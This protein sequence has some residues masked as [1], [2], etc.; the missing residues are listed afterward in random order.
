MKEK[1]LLL[2]PGEK[3]ARREGDSGDKLIFSLHFSTKEIPK[4]SI[5]KKLQ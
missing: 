2:R 5:W 4:E 3:L 1:L